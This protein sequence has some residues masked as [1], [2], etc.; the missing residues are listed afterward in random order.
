[1]AASQNYMP[2]T[3][4]VAEAAVASS[5]AQPP[6]PLA[7]CYFDHTPTVIRCPYC[8]YTGPTQV[9]HKVGS[10][11]WLCVAIIAMVFFPLAWV[12]LCCK[13]C[14]QADHTCPNCNL[15]V[16]VILCSVVF[17]AD[18]AMISEPAAPPLLPPAPMAG[19]YFDHDPATITCPYCRHTGPT[20]VNHNIS[21][22]TWICVIILAII[23][24]PVAWIPCCCKA[25]QQA[26]HRCVKCNV[27]VGEK[28]FITR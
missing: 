9:E 13:D 5:T 12:P 24:F 22:G 4:S 18:V 8:H 26:D 23:F 14:Q 6:V 15:K 19:A 25:C 3:G 2:L 21:L 16:V 28:V 1:M 7:V 10:G 11:T 20:K 17:C 27:K